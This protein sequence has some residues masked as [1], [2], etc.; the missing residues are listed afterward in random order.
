MSLSARAISLSR[1]E[2]QVHRRIS[3]G[4]WNDGIYSCASHIHTSLGMGRKRWEVLEIATALLSLPYSL[5][6]TH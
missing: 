5:P 3:L 1:L 4:G 6:S 2:V